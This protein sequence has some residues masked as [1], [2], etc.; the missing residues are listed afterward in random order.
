MRRPLPKHPCSSGE[1]E[2]QEKGTLKVSEGPGLA[3]G[4]GALPC[5]LAL[6]G[7]SSPGEQL[8]GP[9]DQGSPK[10]EAAGRLTPLPA[11]P[12]GGTLPVPPGYSGQSEPAAPWSR[13]SSGGQAGTQRRELGWV[14]GTARPLDSWRGKRGAVQTLSRRTPAPPG[15]EV[16]QEPRGQ[17]S[18][19]S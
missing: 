13:P 14:R 9:A 19:S 2:G 11:P 18:L 1:T 7:K 10:K 12:S 17:C 6:K 15:L 5:P 3:A 4:P 8:V 16:E